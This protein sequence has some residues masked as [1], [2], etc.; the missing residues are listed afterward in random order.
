MKTPK[1]TAEEMVLYYY[2][3][4]GINSNGFIDLSV[5]FAL[6]HCDSLLITAKGNLMVYL[7]EVITELK[8]TDFKELFKNVTP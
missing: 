5:E 6:N 3:K 2:T 4:I 7:Y 1:E 8:E